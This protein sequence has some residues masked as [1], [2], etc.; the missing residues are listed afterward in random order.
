MEQYKKLYNSLSGFGVCSTGGERKCDTELNGRKKETVVCSQIERALQSVL[1]FLLSTFFSCLFVVSLRLLHLQKANAR[2]PS[3]TA[4]VMTRDTVTLTL[5][6]P[7]I[8][9]LCDV[10]S[11]HTQTCWPNLVVSGLACVLAP[12][13]SFQGLHVHPRAMFVYYPKSEPD[14]TCYLTYRTLR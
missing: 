10:Y 2:V 14:T 1:I 6:Y 11:Q 12:S 9:P 4:A 7:I 8:S 13:R 3:G 5:S